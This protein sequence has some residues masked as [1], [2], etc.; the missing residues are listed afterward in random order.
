MTLGEQ[1]SVEGMITRF[2][3]DAGYRRLIELLKI[4]TLLQGDAAVAQEIATIASLH[5]I[6]SGEI[7]IRQGEV[8]NNLFFILSGTFRVFV[9]GR[10]VAIR[11]SG[12]HLGEM[13]IID[14]ASS[15]TATV[16]ASE[17]SVVAQLNEENFLKLADKNPR[18]WRNLALELCHRLDE[19]KKF[20]SQPNTKP[21]LF[22]GSSSEQLDVAK[23]I[24]AGIPNTV[25]SVTLW[26][27]GVFGASHFTLDDLEAQLKI[28]DFAVLV[29]GADDKVTSRGVR[30]GAPRDN[31]IFEL[32]LFMGALSRSRTFL[33]MPRALKTKRGVKAWLRNLPW[34][35]LK[36]RSQKPKI[37]T[38]L[39]GLNYI[40][41][42]PNKTVPTDM[43]SEALKELEIIITR[44]G[45]K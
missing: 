19:R 32:G 17:Q 22:I 12:Q 39:L 30:S 13:A 35:L 41:F 37:P 27:E 23:S 33:V 42:D 40:Q 8:E 10:E 20:H 14:P 6:S 44:M 29:A 11:T 45:P 26:S 31:V 25:A 36:G 38:D 7:L 2:Q 28:S 3:G 43:V 21:I 15:R 1:M 9:N 24:A 4:Q 5:E 16:I 34:F 18:I